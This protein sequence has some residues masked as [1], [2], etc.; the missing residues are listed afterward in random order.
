MKFSNPW[1]ISQE[2]RGHLILQEIKSHLNGWIIRLAT[3]ILIEILEEFQKNSVVILKRIL[4][5]TLSEFRG[6]LNFWSEY[7]LGISCHFQNESVL[8][9]YWRILQSTTAAF[10]TRI[11]IEILEEF[12]SHLNFKFYKIPIWGFGPKPLSGLLFLFSKLLNQGP[13]AY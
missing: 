12:P 8:S 1:R 2:F 9:N 3:R 11:L 6:H 7:W 10:L 5:K 4:I 13:Y